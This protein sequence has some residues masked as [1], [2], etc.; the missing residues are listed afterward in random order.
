MSAPDRDIRVG[1]ACR[2]L[3]A[4]LRAHLCVTSIRIRLRMPDRDL[5]Y[6]LPNESDTIASRAAVMR[7]RML[8]W[9][10]RDWLRAQLADL[11]EAGRR[12]VAVALAS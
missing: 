4:A 7:A 6:E 8:S 2:A 12:P 9:T 11:D 3:E 1:T 5:A 10:S